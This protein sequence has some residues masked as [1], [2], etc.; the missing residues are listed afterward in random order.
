MGQ[1]CLQ[2]NHISDPQV[3]PFFDQIQNK[4]LR[5]SELNLSQNSIGDQGAESISAGL[6]GNIYVRVLNLCWNKIR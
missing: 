5:M 3:E 2:R 6:R 1:L 4:L